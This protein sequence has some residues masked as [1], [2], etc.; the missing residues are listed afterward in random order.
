MQWPLQQLKTLFITGETFLS[1]GGLTTSF[2]VTLGSY[3]HATFTIAM[4]PYLNPWD[5]TITNAG[6]SPLVGFSLS[7]SYQIFS[8]EAGPLYLEDDSDIDVLIP[9][10]ESYDVYY[11]VF[12][13]ATKGMKVNH[14]YSQPS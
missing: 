8:A 11:S 14:S 12:N 7:N 1:T 6:G 9:T 13:I 5:V 4:C 2:S 10:V 3:W